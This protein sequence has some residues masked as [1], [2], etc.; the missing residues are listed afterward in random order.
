M[1]LISFLKKLNKHETLLRNFFLILSCLVIFWIALYP[2]TPVNVTE[3]NATFQINSGSNLNQIT[4]QLVETELL[5]DS[6]R[7]KTLTFITGNHKKL[8]RGYYKIPSDTSPLKLLDILV[9]G[10]EALF[11]ITLLEGSTFS[12]LLKLIHKNKNIKKTINGN[13]ENEILKLIG[14]EEKFIEGLFYPDTYYFRKNTSDVE[15]L[16]NAYHVMQAKIK[17]LWENRTDNLPYKSSYEAL[18]I[19]SIIEKEIGILEEAPEIAGVFVNRLS[20]GMPLQSDP[21]VIYGMG[22]EFKGNIRR[23]DLKKDNMYNTYTRKGIPP[24]PIATASLNSL[25]AALNPATTENFYFVAKGNRMHHFSKT[26]KEHNRAVNKYQK[27]R[28]KKR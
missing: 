15:I 20:I 19:A 6:L 17:F 12:Q 26:V 9:K 23:K 25:E 2:F 8:K 1:K 18:V 3:A 27:K 16:R 5:N 7:F 24:S 28:R 11:P 21:T 4:N 10:K 13:D 22:D 14:A